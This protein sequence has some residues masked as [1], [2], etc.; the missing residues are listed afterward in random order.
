M[1]SSAKKKIIITDINA[2]AHSDQGDLLGKKKKVC[3]PKCPV[4]YV[5]KIQTNTKKKGTTK[6]VVKPQKINSL[7]VPKHVF[8]NLVSML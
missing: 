6:F 1:Y 2:G 5:K 4:S 8:S 7:A 3:T